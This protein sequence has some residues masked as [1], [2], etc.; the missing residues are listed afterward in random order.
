MKD[1]KWVGVCEGGAVNVGKCAWGCVSGKE[2]MST[3]EQQE[4]L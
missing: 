3:E 4:G 2:G 1:V